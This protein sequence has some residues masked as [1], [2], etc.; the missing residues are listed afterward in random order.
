MCSRLAVESKSNTDHN[1]TQTPCLYLFVSREPRLRL[2][3]SL[4]RGRPSKL[5]KNKGSDQATVKGPPSRVL[6][7]VRLFER[8]QVRFAFCNKVTLRHY[9]RQ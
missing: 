3:P 8:F 4:Q 5:H 6:I 7:R 9:G 1:F 2:P